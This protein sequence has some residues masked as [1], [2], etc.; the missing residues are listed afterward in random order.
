MADPTPTK[1]QA[2]DAPASVKPC[3]TC[4]GGGT[5]ERTHPRWGYRNC[6]DPTITETC[7]TCGGVGA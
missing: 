7:P 5:V 2:N 3:A 1:A 6:P 4:H